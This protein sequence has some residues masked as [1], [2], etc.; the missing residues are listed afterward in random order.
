[1]QRYIVIRIFQ[2]VITLLIL[3]AVIFALVRFSGDPAS[4]MLSE[5]A[6]EEDYRYMRAQLGLDKPI[7]VQYGIFIAKAVR[8][9]FGESIRTRKPVLESIKEA[10]PNSVKLVAVSMFIAFT[11]SL[12]LGV[13][14]A[15]KKGT[16]VDTFA[17]VLAGLGQS[18]PT[19]WVGL[20]MIHLFV[21]LLG[22]LPA[23]GMASWK[24]YLMPA[25]CLGIF[26]MAGIVRLLRSSM[27]E[28]LDSEYIKMARIKGV[29]EGL[30]AWKHGLRNSLLSV[31]SFGG[32]YIAIMITGAILVETVFAWPGFGRLSYGAIVGQDFPLIQGVVLTAGAVVMIANL[33]TDILYAY[34]D[35]RIR[36][37]V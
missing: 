23:S 12:P 35:P 26:I 13:M 6:T 34:L 8:G 11:L 15:V 31:L 27:L 14:A 4:L 28:V 16:Y 25:S 10:L 33:I 9:D 2:T 18:L 36:Y 7:Y 30:V 5:N 19:F 22:V 24:H 37:R 32:M 17:R 3:S 1:M 21:I 29:S 20:M